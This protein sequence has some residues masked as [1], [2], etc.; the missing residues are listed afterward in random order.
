M[1][2]HIISLTFAIWSINDL[3]VMTHLI[4]RIFSP[5]C[6]TTLIVLPIFSR[7]LVTFLLVQVSY[8]VAPPTN[9]TER[10]LF[11]Y[12]QTIFLAEKFVNIRFVVPFPFF[13]NSISQY[14][15]DIALKLD[16]LWNSLIY[17]CNLKDS[18]ITKMNFS[19]PWIYEET[20]MERIRS[21]DDLRRLKL[22][23]SEMFP[24]IQPSKSRRTQLG[25]SLSAAGL[26]GSAAAG[27][28]LGSSCFLKGI[29]AGCDQMS[30]ENKR[31][32]NGAIQNMKS[33]HSEWVRVQNVT[34]DKF[35]LVWSGLKE[36]RRIQG[37]MASI[38]RDNAQTMMFKFSRNV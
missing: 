4:A 33:M 7:V 1:F 26:W 38:H 37:Q 6:Y 22:E 28:V 21:Q 24:I 13:D 3:Y 20:R 32:I 5:I 15:T 29:F 10:I 14:I 34:N 9:P 19:N 35:Y 36:L 31:D 2:F 18:S 17:V 27:L 11:N 8:E 16:D 23:L 30:K 12:Q 25:V